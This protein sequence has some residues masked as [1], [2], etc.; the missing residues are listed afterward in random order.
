MSNGIDLVEM[1][2]RPHK[3]NT[4]LL[5]KRLIEKRVCAFINKKTQFLDN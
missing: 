3:F 1:N 2:K 4:D 5:Q